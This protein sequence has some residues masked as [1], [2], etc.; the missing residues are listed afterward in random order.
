MKTGVINRLISPDTH[1][2]T[3]E[4]TVLILNCLFPYIDD[5]LQLYASFFNS[6]LLNKPLKDSIQGRRLKN[7]F[8][9]FTF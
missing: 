7:S 4:T 3:S 5:F 6:K 2:E 8:Y 1:T 9:Y